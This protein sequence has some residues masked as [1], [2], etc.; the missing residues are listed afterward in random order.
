MIYIIDA[1]CREIVHVLCNLF[2]GFYNSYFYSF[3]F[4]INHS[5]S[6]CLSLIGPDMNEVP[7]PEILQDPDIDDDDVPS[8]NDENNDNDDDDDYNNDDGDDDYD[9]TYNNDLDDADAD[10]TAA[11]VL[12]GNR[13]SRRRRGGR[14][15]RRGGRGRRTAADEE[16]EEE[17]E[18]LMENAMKD[19]QPIA[20]LDTYGTEDIDNR[21]YDNMNAD[22]RYAAEAVLQAR[23][24]ERNLSAMMGGRARG[25]YGALDAMEEDLEE[26]E[27][28]MRRRAMFGRSGGGAGGGGGGDGGDDDDDDGMDDDD[29]DNDNFEDEEGVNLE[30][31]DVPLREWI[32]QDRT[33][34]EIQ[35]KFRMFLSTFREGEEFDED[36][37]DDPALD[38]AERKRRRRLLAQTPPTYEDRIRQMCSV[39]KSALELSY[40]HLMQK[41]PTLA[42]WVNEAPRDMLDVLNEAATRHTLRLFPSYHTIRDEIHVRIADV[43]I[44]DSLRDL[45]RAHLDGLVK[46]SGVITRRS[47]VFPQLKLAFYDCIKCKAIMGP[48]RVEDTTSHSSG[49][50]GSRDV[51]DLHSPTICRECD[52]EGPFKLNSTRSR[53]R[54]YQ[55]VNLQ[56]RPGSVP[57][58]RVPRTKEVVFLDDLVDIARPGEEVE[59]TGIFCHSYDYYL[60]QRSG[61][62]VFQTYVSA[63][64]IRKKEDASS[65]HNLSEADR[66]LIL[67]LAADPNIAKRIVAS[68]APSIYGH[69]HVKMSLAMALFGAV[70]KNVDDKHRIRGDVNVLILGDPGTAKSQM[71]KYAEATAPRAVYSAGKGA[72]AVGLTANVHKDPITREWTLEGGMSLNDYSSYI[73]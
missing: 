42:L 23:D 18:D 29:L 71:L 52:S 8:D 25:F 12:F 32:A 14:G 53:Y 67:E 36:N 59:V 54:N 5:L 45:R 28:R 49:P 13:D 60:T 7:D 68:I 21:E 9:P 27:E 38:E 66:K 30:A 72:S 50:D 34:R 69:E 64:H 63:N 20:A 61:F 19:Y 33:R 6:L 62:P 16:E 57:P 58:G 40:L 4:N 73:A 15:G 26:E 37:L 24:K 17:G 51:S 11:Q 10:G 43:P 44:I 46:V 39:N 2:V 1:T 3:I 65:A 35:R 48:F 47:G 22:E 55:R 56:E 70:P 41:E 31:F